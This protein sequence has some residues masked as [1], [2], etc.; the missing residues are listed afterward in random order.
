M[1]VVCQTVSDLANEKRR[2]IG[3]DR[4]RQLSLTRQSREQGHGRKALLSPP[5]PAYSRP[6]RSYQ[7]QLA[8]PGKGGVPQAHVRTEGLTVVADLDR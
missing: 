8:T 4:L 7:D 5:I 6:A 1:R 3:L 2:V